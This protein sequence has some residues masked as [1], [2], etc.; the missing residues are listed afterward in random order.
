MP[1]LDLL[2]NEKK[3]GKKKDPGAQVEKK[4]TKIDSKNKNEQSKKLNTFEMLENRIK[5]EDSKKKK[6]EESSQVYKNQIYL[7]IN[8]HL[9][10]INLFFLNRKYPKRS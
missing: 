2:I 3:F 9:L 6:F 7:N 5:N 10:N 8:N 4:T 1:T